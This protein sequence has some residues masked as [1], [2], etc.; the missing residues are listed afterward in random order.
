MRSLMRVLVEPSDY[1]LRNAGDMAMMYVAISRL[2]AAW[3][4]ALIE[5]LT[6]D[7]N[8]LAE[9]CP[10][11]TPLMAPYPGQFSESVS[12]RISP[13]A[14]QLRE[15]PIAK[16][17]KELLLRNETA[18]RRL[19]PLIKFAGGVRDCGTPL[20]LALPPALIDSI[21]RADLMVVTGMGGV[22][23]AFPGYAQGLLERIEQALALKKPVFM[24]GQGIGPLDRPELRSKAAAVLPRVTFIALR[25]GRSGIPLLRSLGVAPQRMMVTGDDAIELADASGFANGGRGL[26][27]NLRFAEYAETDSTFVSECGEILQRSAR[28]FEAPMVPIPISSVPGEEDAV[29]IQLL[30]AGYSESSDGGIEVNT[31]FRVIN[32]IKSCRIVFAGSYHAAVFALSLGVPVV[33][34]AKSHYYRDKFLGLAEL[35]GAGCIVILGREP[36]WKSH[37]ANALERAWHGADQLKPL[38]L[39]AAERQLLLSRS[40]YQRVFEIVSATIVSKSGN[41]CGR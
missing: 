17:L 10:A 9:F 11:A 15:L 5:V 25:E 19:W 7:T 31:P 38:L 20:R 33:C 28:K 35:F 8:R 26:G 16:Q 32:Q 30:T 23:D 3:P 39:A 1:V 21:S 12:R 37:L 18:R 24:L 13:I 40:A 36:N 27:V 6:A 2:A 41:L 22:T 34:L 29:T 14:R 4:D